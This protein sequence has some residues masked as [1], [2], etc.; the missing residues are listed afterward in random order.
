MVPR[1]EFEKQANRVDGK[2]RSDALLRWSQFVALKC[3][4]DTHDRT[5]K[6]GGKLTMMESDR[7]V[8]NG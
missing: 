3:R 7:Q 1:L 8:K 6:N 5:Q 4:L 2:R